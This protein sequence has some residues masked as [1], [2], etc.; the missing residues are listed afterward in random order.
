MG[1]IECLF[2][3]KKITFIKMKTVKLWTPFSK[4]SSARDTSV[5]VCFAS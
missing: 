2:A 4:C 1:A 3:F 5:K